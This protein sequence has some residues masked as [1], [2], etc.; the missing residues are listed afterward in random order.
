M[1]QLFVEPGDISGNQFHLRG[2][3]AHHVLRV[4]RCQTNDVLQL[5]DGSGQQYKGKL[6]LVDADGGIV[7]GDILEKLPIDLSQHHIR[8]FQGVPKGTKFDFIVEKAVELGVDE[9]L[10][11]LSQKSVIKFTTEQAQKKSDRWTR[12]AKAAAKQCNRQTI[13]FIAAPLSL[14]ELGSQLN[15]GVTFVF[16]EDSRSR[17]FGQALRSSKGSLPQAARINMIVGPESGLNSKELDWL[18]GLGAQPVSLGKLTLRTETAGLAAL[19]IL[20]YELGLL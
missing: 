15:K 11:Y 14:I 5:F 12:L 10:P 9:I 4:L 16:A 1:P 8:L 17:P 13:P 20:R 19:S 2:P 6:T 18:V 3:E 7:K